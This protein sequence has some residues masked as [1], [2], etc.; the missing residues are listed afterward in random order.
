MVRDL[1]TGEGNMIHPSGMRTTDHEAA[2]VYA[3]NG[4]QI[5]NAA[6]RAKD[7]YV[8][9]RKPFPWAALIGVLAFV[10]GMFWILVYGVAS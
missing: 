7:R 8:P 3:P 2:E 4:A 5:E 6:R 10:I 1:D 9:Y